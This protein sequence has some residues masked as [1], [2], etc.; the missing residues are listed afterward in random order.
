MER[1]EQ[2][3]G[4]RN[5]LAKISLQK[6]IA[7]IFKKTF[8]GSFSPVSYH[9]S[10]VSFS[11]LLFS[12]TA[13]QK[14][15]IEIPINEVQTTTN[16]TL[17]DVFFLDENIGYACG[18]DRYNVGVFMKTKDGGKTWSSAD[19]I[20]P[21]QSYA[22]HFFDQKRGFVTGFDSWFCSTDDSAKNF[23][24]Y[25]MPAYLPTYDLKFQNNTNGVMAG[26]AGLNSGTIYNTK[27]GGGSWNEQRFDFNL[28]CAAWVND[29]RVMVA[30]YGVLYV[31]NDAGET[32]R[33][34]D[35]VRGD[36]FK[37]ICFPTAQTGFLIGWQGMILKTSNGGDTWQ[38]LQSANSGFNKRIHLEAID[39]FDENTG[40]IVGDDGLMYITDNA[41][42]TWKQAKQF[43][44]LNL[45]D[46]HL[47][48]AKSGIACG[49][50]GK[51]FLFN[52]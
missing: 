39:F 37:D 46:V 38:K 26:G 2:Q 10:H 22:I 24:I 29:M 44:N 33:A 31:S 52:F 20:M 28:Q 50:A 27:N 21:K 42:K 8:I 41:G 43:T 3:L 51:V 30:G 14:E 17:N 12:L 11:L 25:Y 18:G 36:F 13:C 47:F 23:G 15:Q 48:N 5:Q 1:K 45:Y 19:S 4:R 40:V 6:Y 34:H 32:W 16:Y 49:E 7:L 35:D 9:I